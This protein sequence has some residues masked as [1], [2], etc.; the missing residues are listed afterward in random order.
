MASMT[1]T[2]YVGSTSNIISRVYEH[3]FG[4]LDGFTKKYKCNRLLYYE[5]LNLKQKALDREQQIKKYNRK[6]KEKLIHDFN[7]EWIDLA[8][9]WY[10]NIIVIRGLI[11][12]KGIPHPMG[13]GIRKKV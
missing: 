8:Q 2:L 12:R 6:K 3:K 1:G 11:H 5:I 13:F 10:D 4:L 7:P 9:N